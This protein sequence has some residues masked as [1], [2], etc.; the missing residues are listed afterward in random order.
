MYGYWPSVKIYDNYRYSIGNYL[1]KP[2]DI[3]FH[4]YYDPE[5]IHKMLYVNRTLLDDKTK[6]KETT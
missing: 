1:A 6:E 4:E 2:N 5:E 3:E